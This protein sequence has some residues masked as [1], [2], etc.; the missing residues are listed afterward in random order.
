MANIVRIF[1]DDYQPT[2]QDLLH[3]YVRTA[4]IAET[5]MCVDGAHYNVVDVPGARSQR[6]KWK[7]HAIDNADAVIFV[8]PMNGRDRCLVEDHTAV[9][10]PG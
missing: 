2:T 7:V 3:T 4:G 1:S 10:F 5:S 8:V 6:R 9:S